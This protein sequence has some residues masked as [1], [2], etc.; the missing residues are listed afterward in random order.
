MLNVYYAKYVMMSYMQKGMLLRQKWHHDV[1]KSNS[2]SQHQ[3][4]GHNVKK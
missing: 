2:I 1:N 4:V 3:R